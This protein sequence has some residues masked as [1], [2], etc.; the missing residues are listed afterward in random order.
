MNILIIDE[1]FPFPL[2]TGKRIRTFSL[3]R[4]LSARNRVSYLAYGDQDSEASKFLQNNGITCHAVKPPDRRQSG[5]LFYTRLLLNL[6]SPLPYIVTSHYTGRFERELKDLVNQHAYDMIICEWT[7]YAIFLKAVPDTKSIIVAHNIEAAIWRRYE[8]NEANPLRRVYIGIQRR[9]VEAFE[10]VCFTWARGATAVTD[11]EAKEIAS[12]GVGYPVQT[13][14]NGVNIEYFQP[15]STP[16]EPDTLVFTGSMDWRPNQDAMEYFV[17]DVL[18]LARRDRPNL[19]LFIVGRKP[20]RHIEALGNIAGV[21]VTGTVDDVRP[22]IARAALYIVPLRIGGGSRLKI[23]EA[24]AMKKPVLSTTVGAEG[25]RITDGENIVIADGATDFAAAIIR[26]LDNSE[27]CDP[28]AERGRL[29]V[30]QEY[31]WDRLGDKLHRYL[32]EVVARP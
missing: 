32:T 5:P 13:V 4:A 6:L 1:E 8:E 21:T 31:R 22:Y 10:R 15:A 27:L 9:K 7:P 20:P 26:C 25:L 14:D 18:P 17:S 16:G 2:N 24:M 28:V 19:K 11:I 12:Y 29:L 23:L 30:E 3:T